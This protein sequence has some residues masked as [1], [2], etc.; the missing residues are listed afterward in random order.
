MKYTEF[1]KKFSKITSDFTQ[2]YSNC[3]GYNVDSGN[4]IKNVLFI[5]GIPG[6][7]KSE[8]TSDLAKHYNC[9]IIDLD[10]IDAN[11][12]PRCQAVMKFFSDFNPD[13]GYAKE[14]YNFLS[15]IRRYKSSRLIIV[16]GRQIYESGLINKNKHS[17]IVTN[18]P[19]EVVIQN[20]M[21]RDHVSESE[22]KRFVDHDYD[23][24]NHWLNK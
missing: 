11:N 13:E 10:E 12:Y 22:A 8:L 2:D 5:T 15:F 18:S 14:S 24:L 4:F 3:I 7:G 17:I 20:R 1:I 9:D 19:R 16:E 6:S 21:K 23:K